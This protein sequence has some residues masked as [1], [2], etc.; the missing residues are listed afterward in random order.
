MHFAV[1]D[2]GSD[3]ALDLGAREESSSVGHFLIIAEAAYIWS[4]QLW[5]GLLDPASGSP[6]WQRRSHVVLEPAA[7]NSFSI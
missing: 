7:V 5:Q 2:S 3:T 6:P 1:A 4:H